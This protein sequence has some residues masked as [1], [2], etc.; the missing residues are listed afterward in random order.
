LQ[1]TR[2]LPW[3]FFLPQANQSGC[4]HY[5]RRYTAG[6]GH[7]ASDRR[8]WSATFS[9]ELIPLI[10]FIAVGLFFLAAGFRHGPAH[11]LPFS[12][13]VLLIYAN[14]DGSDTDHGGT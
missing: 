14:R 12:Q 5:H 6:D 2:R 7:S 4:D 8:Q 9:P 1:P 3:L 11:R 10:L 13:S